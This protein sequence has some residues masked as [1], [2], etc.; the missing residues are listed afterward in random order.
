[1]K[2]YDIKV[3]SAVAASN[4]I[5]HLGVGIPKA[6]ALRELVING[7]EACQRNKDEAGHG[8]I[9]MKDHEYGDKL[10]VVNIGGDFLSQEKIEKHLATLGASGN[11]SI[12]G[13]QVL[14]ANKGIGAKVAYLPQAPLGLLYRSVEK[15]EEEGITVTMCRDHARNVYTLPATYCEFQEVTTSFPACFSFHEKMWVNPS[16]EVPVAR[17]TG[18]EVVCL[19][20]TEDENTWLEFDRLCGI[21]KGVGDGGTGYGIFKYLTH[22]L[23]SEPPV[24]VRSVIYDKASGDRRSPQLVKG[25]KSYIRTKT[26]VNG[27]IPVKVAGFEVQAYWGVV[28]GPADEGYVSNWASSGLTSFA[29]KGETYFDFDQ[30]TYSKKKDV[31]ECGIVVKPD[32]VMIVFEFSN[33]IELSTNAGRTLLYYDNQTI[34][35][36]E[37]HEA[38]REKIPPELVA[39]QEE[40]QQKSPDDKDLFANLQKLFKKR[41]KMKEGDAIE[42]P[43]KYTASSINKPSSSLK[44]AKNKARKTSVGR[45]SSAAKLKQMKCPY[46]TFIADEDE[47]ALCE[48][49]YKAYELV[50]NTAHPLYSERL[51]R[52]VGKFGVACLIKEDVEYLMKFYMLEN[53]FNGIIEVNQTFPA[54]LEAK[55]EHWTPLCLQRAWSSRDEQTIYER[56]K[57]K[58]KDAEI[59]AA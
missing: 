26:K 28:K 23:W 41:Y 29:W 5:N 14:D 11:D 3:D 56:L 18:T 1:M 39:W 13:E 4:V 43:L 45:L 50:L 9:V 42:S 12:C 15:G 36:A 33:N 25:L 34:D 59:L 8:V 38:F 58:Q 32:K 2:G 6:L 27:V 46:L 37:F 10:A 20:S 40:N 47:E 49:H 51:E 48:F 30:S 24:P 22:R 19:G 16:E 53:A 57:S 31:K 7:I 52:L 35:K 17:Y 54:S 44:V 21:R 55:R